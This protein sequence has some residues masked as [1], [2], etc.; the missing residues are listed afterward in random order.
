MTA[1]AK[2]ILDS[3]NSAGNRLTTMQLKYQRFIH[4]EAKTHRVMSNSGEEYEVIALTQ[5]AGF[6]SDSNLSRNAS[7]S[8]AIPVSKMIEQVRND[9]AMPVHWG[10]NMPGMQAR[11]EL[12]GLELHEAKSLW[13]CAAKQA[14]DTAEEMQE[15]GLHKQVANRILEPFQWI[16]VVMT[17]TELYNFFELRDHKDADPNIQALAKVMLEALEGSTP[18]L[19]QA[20]EWHLPYISED[21]QKEN[22]WKGSTTL[23]LRKIS[24]AR[25]A[26]VS[27]LT[28]DGKQPDTF[29]D[30][31]LFNMLAGGVPLHASPL[32]HQG[33]PGNT[34]TGNFQGWTQFRKLWEKVV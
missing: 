21:E 8:R 14:A 11:Q 34:D 6:M 28:H 13:F 1:T 33:T 23:D 25:C 2:I 24:A 19:M 27:Y 12:A 10:A 22:T 15:L 5:D 9:P 7:S 31:Q 4:A 26:R 3:V 18:K 30:L 20:G 29:K 32:E 17:A 16:H